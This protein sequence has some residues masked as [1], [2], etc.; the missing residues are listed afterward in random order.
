MP[1]KLLVGWKVFPFLPNGQGGERLPK[2]STLLVLSV[3]VPVWNMLPDHPACLFIGYVTAPNLVVSTPTFNGHEICNEQGIKDEIKIKPILQEKGN[4]K[5]E[6]TVE[7][8]EKAIKEEFKMIR[9]VKEY[10]PSEGD[11]GSEDEGR[12]NDHE[13]A[14]DQTLKHW[15][16]KPLPS[17]G[18]SHRFIYEIQQVDPTCRRNFSKLDWEAMMDVCSFPFR[19]LWYK[20][21]KNNSYRITRD[22]L[23]LQMPV[24]SGSY[25]NALLSLWGRS[26]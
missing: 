22:G 18:A 13:R 14:E 24:S 11:E 23:Q 8:E 19:K 1:R 21:L 12:S 3:P 15:P 5:S 10:E 20:S 16:Y 9:T 4:S 26:G 7:E 25:M 2:Y 6:T 17:T